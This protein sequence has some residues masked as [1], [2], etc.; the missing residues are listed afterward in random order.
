M[1]DLSVRLLIGTVLLYGLA[2][3]AFA[4]AAATRRAR[5]GHRRHVARTRQLVGAGAPV[6]PPARS[7]VA[8]PHAADLAGRAGRDRA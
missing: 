7:A 3:L 8:P 4:G 2:M 1:A 5:A 6:P